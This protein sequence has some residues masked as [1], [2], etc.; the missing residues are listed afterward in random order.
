MAKSGKKS[1]YE[2]LCEVIKE[3]RNDSERTQADVGKRLGKGD[4]AQI[5]VAKVEAGVRQIDV[6]EFIDICRAIGVDPIATF[7]KLVDLLGQ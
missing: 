7:S 5:F 2:H 3:A 1:P 6:I 4:G